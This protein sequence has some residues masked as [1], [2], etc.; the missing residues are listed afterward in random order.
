MSIEDI[1]LWLY[2]M[3]SGFIFLRGLRKWESF[4][5]PFDFK[6]LDI[7]CMWEMWAVSYLPGS[8]RM[9]VETGHGALGLHSCLRSA[10][11]CPGA[12]VLPSIILGR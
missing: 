4:R 12:R 3:A 2:Q 1:Y 8:R 10:A 11:R 5:K 6:N 9:G 7:V